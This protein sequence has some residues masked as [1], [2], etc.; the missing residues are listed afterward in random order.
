MGCFMLK[1]ETNRMINTVTSFTSMDILHYVLAEVDG[2]SYPNLKFV[3]SGIKILNS[4]KNFS[5]IEI[6]DASKL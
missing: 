1:L 5:G 6:L 4:H 2:I 3:D